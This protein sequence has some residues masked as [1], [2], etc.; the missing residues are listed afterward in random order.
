MPDGHSALFEAV[1]RNKR[2]LALDLKS[3]RG[4]EIFRELIVDTDV[5][6][7]NYRPGT[8]EKLGLSTEALTELNPGLIHAAT[9]GYGF[10]GDE[11]HLPALDAVGQARGVIAV[12]IAAG[13][14]EE[15]LLKQRLQR[16][17]DLRLLATVRQTRRQG[18]AQLELLVAR[19]EQNRS[20]VGAGV[21]LVE[22]DGHRLLAHILEQN[23][24]FGGMV[25]HAKALG[26]GKCLFPNTIFAHLGAF[27]L[28][29][30]E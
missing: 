20:T 12:G 30:H 25:C 17:G 14:G 11:A 1:N 28:S 23:T 15:A 21:I 19:L 29:V 16:M 27:V 8:F 5:F 7:E 18:R 10:K 22:L 6:I 2:S 13:D 9:A 26:V 4:Q 3:E 24:L